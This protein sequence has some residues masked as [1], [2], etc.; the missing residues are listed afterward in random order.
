MKTIQNL[1]GM[2][3][4]TISATH[5]ETADGLLIQALPPTRLRVVSVAGEALIAQ[6]IA[7]GKVI[8]DYPITL[9]RASR[10][11]IRHIQAALKAAGVA[12][13]STPVA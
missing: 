9:A 11:K 4:I 7:H 3:N 12:D 13:E 6:L 8:V 2:K 10:A 5:L 1:A